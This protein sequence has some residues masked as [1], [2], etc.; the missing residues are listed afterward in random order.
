MYSFCF[1]APTHCSP[2]SSLGGIGWL[3]SGWGTT[4]A[5]DVFS[6][7]LAYQESYVANETVVIVVA[8]VPLLRTVTTRYFSPSLT[9][10]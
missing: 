8:V 7:V 10:G 3:D 9:M 5:F 4:P 1:T 6:R 2:T